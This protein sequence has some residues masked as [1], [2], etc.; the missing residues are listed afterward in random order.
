MKTFYWV[1]GAIGVLGVVL[2]GLSMFRTRGVTTEQPADLPPDAFS[3]QAELVAAARGIPAGPENAPVKLLV[4]S[5]Y[6][7]PACQHFATVVE[8]G[9]REQYIN[10]GQVQLVYYDFPLG[11]AHKYSFLASRAGRCALDQNKF[12]EYHDHLFKQQS[13]WAFSRNAPVQQF[14]DYAR[15]LGLNVQD[16]ESCLRSDKHSDV[17]SA[18]RALGIKLGV[19]GTPTVYMN[20]RMVGSAWSDPAEMKRLIDQQL[21]IGG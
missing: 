3:S 10:N 17:V 1:L 5:D 18:N 12:W 8:P 6:M 7:C 19:N 2:I 13:N 15:E 14:I 11:G 9:I 20:G 16:F 4:F 21:G